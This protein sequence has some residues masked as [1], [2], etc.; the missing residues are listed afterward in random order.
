MKTP[1]KPYLIIVLAW[2]FYS[3]SCVNCPLWSED[4]SQKQAA[5]LRKDGFNAQ[6]KGDYNK[7]LS[8]YQK[9]IE[10][11]PDYVVV[12]NDLGII[13]EKLQ[14]P[15]EAEKMYKKA[16]ELDPQYA[17]VYTN[18]ALLYEKS[19]D[20]EAAA[21]MWKKRVD[22]GDPYDTWTINAK[23]HLENLAKSDKSLYKIYEDNET[24]DL[25]KEVKDL[26]DKSRESSQFAA[27]VYFQR[28]K[29]YYQ[30]GEYVLALKELSRATSLDPTN[31]D[32]E[33]LLIEAQK[34]CLNSN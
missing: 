24:L 26:K 9:A 22:V 20:F 19:K 34:R 21:H 13:Y 32:I 17:G 4:S 7:A 28:G 14:L 3:L 16:I 31:R 25:V 2:F 5:M 29:D 23:K 8:F 30:K 6:L 33:K 15:N 27:E 1:R 11:N 18:L 12:Y 10:L